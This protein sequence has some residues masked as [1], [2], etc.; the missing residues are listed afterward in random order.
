MCEN[1]LQRG[2]SCVTVC[3]CVVYNRSP[4]L[5]FRAQVG[6]VWDVVTWPFFVGRTCRGTE[7]DVIRG[8]PLDVNPHCLRCRCNKC[9]LTL[10]R[11]SSTSKATWTFGSDTLSHCSVIC[12]SHR[13]RT[14][15]RSIWQCR[16]VRTSH[17]QNWRRYF[18]KRPAYRSGA[19]GVASGCWI[20]GSAS[21]HGVDARGSV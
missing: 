12:G 5:L 15:A 8:I 11:S 7:A 9:K 19:D 10:K 21:S 3:M 16:V 14:C 13:C 1:A 18:C 4:M 20:S 2:R 17:E 6:M